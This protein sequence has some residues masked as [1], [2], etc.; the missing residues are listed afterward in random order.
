ML[1]NLQSAFAVLTCASMVGYAATPASIGI[2]VTS[3]RAFVDG[4]PVRG[5]STLFAG[6]VVRADSAISSLRFA[7]GSSLVL[8]PGAQVKV[9]SDHSVLE[10]GVVTQ[11]GGQKR[12]LI[13]DGLTIAALSEQGSVS[14]VVRDGSHLEAMAQDGPGEVRTP[15][16]QLVA[17]LNPGQPLTFSIS[18]VQAA[19]QQQVTPPPPG[20]TITVTGILRQDS[21]GNYKIGD[22][23]DGREYLVE[24]RIPGNLLGATVQITGVASGE[25]GTILCITPSGTGTEA[26]HIIIANSFRRIAAGSTKEPGEGPAPAAEGPHWSSGLI[27]LGVA[28]AGGGA[29]IAL[30]VANGGK[31]SNSSSSAP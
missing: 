30:L 5:N 1:R 9:Y 17:H 21:N 6:S 13:V 2:M 23:T 29:L 10:Q 12:A 26:C 25:S 28:V 24:G 31:G 16:G 7:D 4:S 22:D 19:G 11:R 14:A 18:A 15:V 3:G 20:P 8:R 27:V